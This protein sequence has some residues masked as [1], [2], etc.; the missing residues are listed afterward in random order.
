MDDYIES[1]AYR[2]RSGGIQPGGEGEISGFILQ[3]FGAEKTTIY[4]YPSITELPESEDM[5]GLG[6][7]LSSASFQGTNYTVG[8]GGDMSFTGSKQFDP[9]F[10]E[11]S[12]IPGG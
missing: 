1:T 2:L 12:E 11:E 3:T 5:L 9:V 7:N 8:A 4:N 10:I 6:G